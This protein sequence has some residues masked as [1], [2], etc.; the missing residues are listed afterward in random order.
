MLPIPGF[1]LVSLRFLLL[2]GVVLALFAPAS[3]AGLTT[4]F[5]GFLERVEGQPWTKILDSFGF[6]SV[7]PFLNFWL[8]IFYRTFHAD[9]LGWHLV[10]T[11]FHSLNSL[12]FW[13]VFRHQQRHIPLDIPAWIPLVA[14]LLFFIHPYA[15]EVVVW[16]ACFNYLLVTTL[17][18]GSLRC[19]Q[20]WLQHP[21]GKLWAGGMLLSSMALLTMELA[22]TL[23]FLSAFFIWVE[24]G[25]R[26]IA[27]KAW[28]RFFG[29]Q[30]LLLMGYLFLS[31]L[32]LGV[33]IGHYGSDTHFSGSLNDWIGRGYMYLVKH[34][35]Y[36]RYWPHG[37][38]KRPIFESLDQWMV[39][40]P[41]LAGSTLVLFF[42]IRRPTP[43]NRVRINA[44]L[45]FGASLVPV[46]SLYFN[47]LLY[48]END[49]YGY[50]ASAFLCWAICLIVIGLPKWVQLLVLGTYFLFGLYWQQWTIKS[51]AQGQKVYA[52]LLESFPSDTRADT[53]YLLNLPDNFRGAPL[54]RD[55]SGE[56]QGFPD[57]L[58][59]VHGD[60]CRAIIVE[61]VQYNMARPTDG[62]SVQLKPHDTLRV[63]FEQWGNWW[64]RQ[65][66]GATN[67]SK[68][69]YHW[70][71]KGH[72][73]RL[74]FDST[75]P[76]ALFLYQKGDVWERLGK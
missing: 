36:L 12:L 54:F 17:I 35:F 21:S 40:A 11:A 3:E 6:P 14:A 76:N 43:L 29:G 70:E 50:L 33:W 9:P 10:F 27:Q 41:L 1:L 45:A 61:V 46:L 42:L 30:L 62:V 39:L 19:T 13:K 8:F 74:W 66:I 2:W 58:R 32:K 44:L 34:L 52:G 75:P 28:L 47:Y 5:T 26:Q 57:A 73:Y 22:F 68:F 53:V 23:P 7:Q 72:H 65:G 71:N 63:E 51:W 67:Y 59:Y 31:R 20:E 60:S 56:A 64:W 48:I 16:K 25:N 15:V 69:N 38:W 49:R 37:A 24:S 18:L 55:Y 4:D